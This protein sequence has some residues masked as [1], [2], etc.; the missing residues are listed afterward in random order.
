MTTTAARGESDLSCS[1]VRVLGVSA[2]SV[3]AMTWLNRWFKDLMTTTDLS[4][5]WNACGGL[6]VAQE[7]SMTMAAIHNTD[8][9][10][11]MALRLLIN[12]SCFKQNWRVILYA[13][14]HAGWR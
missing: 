12:G 9:D 8:I 6:G 14:C 2:I 1:S 7:H 13:R 3:G 10:L 4:R 11:F 5:L